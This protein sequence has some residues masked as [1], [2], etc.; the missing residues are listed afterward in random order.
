M[1][2][3]DDFPKISVVTCGNQC[4]SRRRIG[5]IENHRF[6]GNFVI[7]AVDK[8]IVVI[9]EFQHIDPA[10]AAWPQSD[11]GNSSI[12]VGCKFYCIPVFIHNI[13]QNCP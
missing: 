5:I 2:G 6:S 3:T 11:S 12:A 8:S 1:M 10:L 9:A 7:D 4:R 13:L